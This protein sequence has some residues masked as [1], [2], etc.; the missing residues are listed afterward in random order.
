MPLV[1]YN[2][3][4]RQKEPFQP[5]EPGHVRMYV[6]GVTVYDECHI[7]HARSAIAFDVLYRYLQYRGFRVTYVRNFT[8]VDDKILQRAQKENVPWNELAR[9]Y[10][11][12]FHRDMD[13]LGIRR[14]TLEPC[15][16]QHI[17]E[18]IQAIQA[19]MDRGLAYAV[20]GNVYFSVSRF[21]DYGKL[22]GRDRDQMLAG[23]RVEVDPHKQD[24]LDFALW[25]RSREGEPSWESP[26]GPGRPG[27][28][29]ECSAM[30]QKYLGTTFDIHGGGLDLI[31]PH[32]ENEIAQAEGATG[33]PFARFWVHNGPL[34][35]EGV[36]MSK[37]LGNVLSIQEALGR[38]HPEELRLFMLL[39]HYR[40]PLDFTDR[41]MA[42]V[43]SALDRLYTT[44]KR[45][46][47]LIQACPPT[48][49]SSEM[50]GPRVGPGR[51][52]LEKV[53]AFPERFQ[54]A[55]DDDLNTAQ[56][57]G[58]LFDLN[59][60]LNQWLDHST[61]SSAEENIALLRRARRCYRLCGEVLGTPAADPEAFYRQKE[62]RLL[63]SLGLTREEIQRLIDRRSSARRRKDWEEADRIREDL[64]R[65]GIQLQDTPEGTLWKVRTDLNGV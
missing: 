32:H 46:D 63:A 45:M 57:L 27:W 11:E 22:S 44:L 15:A 56:A 10:M 43:R 29:I 64:H 25:K 21:S 3:L 4:S 19:L 12:A 23:A 14:P 38:Y 24:P 41:G 58:Y 20:D 31:F 60:V 55:M 34:T 47:Q 18:M 40:K 33:K 8:D 6:C 37:S 7:G 28:H 26:W 48:D 13:A 9:R 39:G 50:E 1:L 36:K 16:T 52:V 42:E 61:F 62:E 54:Q 51:G 53:R 17:P 65:R 59:R 49:E 5:L 30:S 2:S 35:R